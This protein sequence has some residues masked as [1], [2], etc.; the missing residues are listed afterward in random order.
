MR[1]L[2]GESAGLGSFVVQKTSFECRLAFIVEN[3]RFRGLPA[4][5]RRSLGRV[6]P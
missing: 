6:C 2:S 1:L 5:K 4:V 3:L